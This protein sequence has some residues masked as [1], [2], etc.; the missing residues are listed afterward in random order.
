MQISESYRKTD[1]QQHLAYRV[2]EESDCAVGNPCGVTGSEEV[3]KDGVN[4][5]DRK[6]HGLREGSGPPVYKKSKEQVG[7]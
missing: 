7:G 4:S 2:G 3:G 6:T 1:S 5:T